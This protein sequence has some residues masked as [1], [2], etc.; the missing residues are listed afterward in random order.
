V[1]SVDLA[2][3][4]VPLDDVRGYEHVRVFFIWSG[5]PVA[6]ADI[7]NHGHAVS[8]ARLLDVAVQSCTTP[9]IQRMLAA[10][11]A[12]TPNGAERLAD[13][14][15]A[16]VVVAT[17]DRPDQLRGCLAA[18]RAQA[19]R[20]PLELV[21]VDNGPASGLT[22]PVVKEF[23]GFVLVSE[24]RQGLAYARNAGFVAARGAIVAC[25]DD[26]VV[27]PPGWIEALAAPFRDPAVMAVTG[28]VLPL[29]LESAAQ[30]FYEAYGGLGRGF[31]RR[32]VDGGWFREFRTAV[33]TWRLGATANAAFRAT[34]FADPAIGLMDEALGPGM[35]SGVGE[36]TYLFYKVLKAGHRLVYEPAA[37]VW[38]RHRRTIPELRRQMYGYSKGHVAYHLT[39][40]LR[41]RDRRA[42]IRL[43]QLPRGHV[44]QIGRWAWHR[45]QGRQSYPLS[46]V[47]LEIWGHLVGPWSLW[48][49]R[50]RVRRE[51][52]SG[53]YVGRS[54]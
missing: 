21:V 3:P 18:L 13:D 43:A 47:L 32:V 9:I 15:P 39:T 7:D 28:N 2:R 27:I 33:P 30:R 38:H 19:T 35:P 5:A 22:G 48:Q 6:S 25:T 31:E 12:P 20:R 1:R 40:L 37:Y 11:L 54:S 24:P 50:R 8:A 45:L 52:R 46:L 53:P 41:D 34:I 29:E 36:D 16:S 17:L 51:G 4:L 10:H 44:R 14:V 42:L 49:S 26:D 23:P